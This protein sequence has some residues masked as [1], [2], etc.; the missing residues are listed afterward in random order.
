ME[1]SITGQEFLD[2]YLEHARLSIQAP[3]FPSLDWDA[4]KPTQQIFMNEQS[5]IY[6]RRLTKVEYLETVRIQSMNG[7]HRELF[8]TKTQDRYAE[9]S[10]LSKSLNARL[11][12][13]P[14]I[15]PEVNVFQSKVL[16][17]VLS[18]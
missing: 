1:H 2:E 10:H 17:E 13:K 9:E 14:H 5:I 3:M 6:R 12:K 15:G 4:G 18:S 7:H 16:F 11:K 8:L